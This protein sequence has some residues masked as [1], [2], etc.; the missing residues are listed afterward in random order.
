M[1]YR[2][3]IIKR[4]NNSFK[5]SRCVVTTHTVIDKQ[6]PINTLRDAKKLAIRERQNKYCESAVVM[7]KMP[8]DHFY[9]WSTVFIAVKGA[10]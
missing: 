6:H 10:K 2:V 4:I 8:K 1:K 3:D 7:K 9:Q 5:T